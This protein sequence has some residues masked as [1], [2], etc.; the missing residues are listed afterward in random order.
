MYQHSLE[1]HHCSRLAEV[2]VAVQLL[3]VQVGHPSAAQAEP[4][5]AMRLVPTLL[6]VVVAQITVM[7]AT[8][9]LESSTSG[10]R[11]NYGSLRKG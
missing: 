7:V 10:T 8:V 5:M 3:V 1:A 4:Q 11:S 9:V 2:A 6:L